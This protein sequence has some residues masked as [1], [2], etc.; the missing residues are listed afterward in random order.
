[1]D[2]SDAYARATNHQ[3]VAARP[4]GD[5]AAGRLVTSCHPGGS[6]RTTLTSLQ[7]DGYRKANP[8]FESLIAC[9]SLGTV[10]EGEP[11]AGE[12]VTRIAGLDSVGLDC[13]EDGD[14]QAPN[15]IATNSGAGTVPNATWPPPMRPST[16]TW[17]SSTSL[18]IDRSA[19]TCWSGGRDLNS[20]SPGP[21]AE[22]KAYRIQLDPNSRF[23]NGR[24]SLNSLVV[25]SAGVPPK[26]A[27]VS[28]Q[29]DSMPGIT[30]Q[31]QA[32]PRWR[33]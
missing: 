11:K 15:T 7:P 26:P 18:T 10:G 27:V 1:M 4:A 21:K 3:S 25:G 22:A 28:S 19:E 31:P 29:I 12:L 8:Y 13:E 9:Q 24:K 2:W 17:R 20:R 14:S 32:E 23:G 30:R 16:S 5:C 6:P 33:P